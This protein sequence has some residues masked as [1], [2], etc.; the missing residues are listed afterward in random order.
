M[1]RNT[2]WLA[3][4]VL[5]V[6]Q[7]PSDEEAV[8][9]AWFEQVNALDDTDESVEALVELYAADALHITGPESHQLG[10][11]TFAGHEN[12]R[13]MARELAARYHDFRFRIEVITARE[14]SATLF[15]RAEGPWGGAS[16]AV[17]YVAAYTRRDDEQRFMFPGAAFFQLE[18][19]KIR[20]LRL[21]HATGEVAPV[22]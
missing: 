19:G 13:T 16:V 6:S 4:L 10:T 21:Y 11:V 5:G 8:V 9:R 17:E 22:E 14:E 20:R 7:V 3:A 12:I 18:E 15:H 1:L 2:I